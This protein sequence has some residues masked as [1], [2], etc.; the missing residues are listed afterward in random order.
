MALSFIEAVVLDV[1]DE[2]VEVIVTFPL[3]DDERLYF[4]LK[5]VPP[6]LR[7]FGTPITIALNEDK[8][9][10]AFQLRYVPPFI[11]PPTR[12]EWELEEWL[13]ADF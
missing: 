10:L 9:A 8:S 5:I 3:H 4:P 1:D 13:N 12:E 7:K 6:G 11:G 2:E